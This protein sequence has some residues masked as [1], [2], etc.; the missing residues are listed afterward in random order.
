MK[1]AVVIPARYASSRFPGKP[2]VLINNKPMIVWVAEACA[3]AV[4]NDAVHIATDDDRIA[5]V[6]QH[7]G[8]NVVMTSPNALT[9]TDRIAEAAQT[10][11]ADVF[12]N[13]QGD[14]PLVNPE[15]IRRIRDEKFR[16]PGEVVNGYCAIGPG[17]D[18]KS[19]N[20]PKVVVGEGARLLYMS[21]L[22][23]PGHKDPTKEPERY[24]KQVCIYAFNRT[25]LAA[26]A[27]LGRKSDVEACEDIE[28]LRFLSLGIPVRMVPTTP[29][30]Q[31]VDSPED[32]KT[33]ETLL[34]SRSQTF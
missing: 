33:I 16:H 23:I 8:H 30:T 13:V 9:G 25:E 3:V 24:L 14:E 1:A 15:D 19:V 17:E 10:I 26:Y 12:L 11:D 34:S 2:L 31:A 32:V 20:I 28:I 27:Q 5:S 7:A 18:P 21:R 29:G 6:V 22:P 4:G